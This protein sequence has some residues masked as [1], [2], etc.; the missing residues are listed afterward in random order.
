[1]S[2]KHL[3]IKLEDEEQKTGLPERNLMAA[4]LERALI[5]AIG[6]SL[7]LRASL[8]RQA[9]LWINERFEVLAPCWSF[10]WICEQLDLDP[11]LVRKFAIEHGQRLRVH[12]TESNINLINGLIMRKRKGTRRKNNVVS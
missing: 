8:K 3:E 7:E 12:Q 9:R 11:E 10:E 6:Q 4:I 2:R 1:L 5:D